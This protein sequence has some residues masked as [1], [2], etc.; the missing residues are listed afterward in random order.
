MPEPWL[1]FTIFVSVQFLLFIIHAYFEKKLSDA[2]RILGWGILIG[3]AVGLSFDLV[4][5]KFFG[6][7]SYTLGFGP[8]SL[9]LSA[10]LVYGLFA[11]HTL[12]MQRAR[13]PHFFLWTMLVG[14]VFYEITNYF[15]PVW[16]YEFALPPLGFLT[17]LL[18]GN[19]AAA[20]LVAVIWHVF[21]GHR[22]FFIDAMLKK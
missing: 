16:T 19:F 9:A 20:L 14:V 12:L 17:F 7:W 22:F 11:A 10:S 21:L 1:N 4:L 3:I 18:V 13:L 8:M 5:G 6:L 2:P 15:F